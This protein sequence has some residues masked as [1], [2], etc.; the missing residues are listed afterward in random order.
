MKAGSYSPWEFHGKKIKCPHCNGT[1][2][3]DVWINGPTVEGFKVFKSL[4]EEKD[5]I[6]SLPRI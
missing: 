6:R 3:L 1:I 4:E 5:Y 2:V